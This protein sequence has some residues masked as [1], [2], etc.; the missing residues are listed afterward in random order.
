MSMPFSAFEDQVLR[1][2]PATDGQ[3]ALTI[4]AFDRA[5]PIDLPPALREK[6]RK[7]FG[8]IDHIPEEA[9]GVLVVIGGRGWGKTQRLIGHYGLWRMLTASLVGLAPGEWGFFAGLAPDVETGVQSLRFALGVAKATPS[10]ARLIESESSDRFVIA[11]PDGHRVA[12][13]VFAASKGGS[14]V[15]GRSLVG[16]GFDEASF[17]RSKE[18]GQI[19]DDDNV[20]AA[21]PW[22]PT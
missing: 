3:R 14:S 20:S 12:F 19:N 2:Q 21:L 15:R 10:I 1:A 9:R 16:A 17:F 7:I 4:V 6:A 5:Q 22:C 18:T 8:P 11:R 13:E